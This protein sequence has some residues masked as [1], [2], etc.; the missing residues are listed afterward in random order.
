MN[1][2]T[3]GV[4]FTVLALGAIG[5][6]VA[7]NSKEDKVPVTPSTVTTSSQPEGHTEETATTTQ[8]SASTNDVLSGTV[9][10]DIQNSAFA[11]P[12]IKVKKGTKVVWT[13]Q[14][15]VEHDVAPDSPSDTFSGSKLLSKGESYEFTFDTTGTY[16]Y[17][18]TPHPF[19]KGTIEVVA[20]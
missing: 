5:A 12:A 3:L 17:H 2:T 10:M 16:T 7:V 19:M 1:K 11:K 14:D 18:C 13:N 15:R 8:S 4:I 9:A 20:E 6:I